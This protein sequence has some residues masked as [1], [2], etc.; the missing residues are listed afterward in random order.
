VDLI[1]EN[2][3]LEL[4][5]AHPLHTHTYE[6]EIETLER[7]PPQPELSLR[8]MTTA[9][10]A[11]LATYL[12][13][14]PDSLNGPLEVT[15]MACAECGRHTTFLDFAKS[16]VDLGAHSRG[17]LAD[18]LTSRNRAWITIVGSDGGRDISCA[19]CGK[20]LGLRETVD[21]GYN[22]GAYQYRIGN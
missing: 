22:G 16:A 21:V 15:E 19:N 1:S 20:S 7:L 9:E 17:S 12:A 2:E 5:G 6:L 14:P 11:E 8:Q 4:L 10:I 18:V 3:L 13:V